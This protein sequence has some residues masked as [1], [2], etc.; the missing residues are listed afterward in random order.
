MT[1]RKIVSEK[2]VKDPQILEL[3]ALVTDTI[4]PLLTPEFTDSADRLLHP[5]RDFLIIL[6]LPLLSLPG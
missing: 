3:L 5:I 1:N 2:D 6:Y 4:L